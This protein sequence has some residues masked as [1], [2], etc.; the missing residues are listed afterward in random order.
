MTTNDIAVRNGSS[1]AVQ[2]DQTE[3]TDKQLAALKQIGVDSA[4]SGDLAV[5]LHQCQRTGLDPFARQVY[6][7]GRNSQNPRTKQWETKYTIQTG[8]DGYR[9]IARRAADKAREAIG[10]RDTQWCGP[11]GKWVDVWLSE[12]PPAAAKVT[13]VRNGQ[14]FPAIALWREY[15]QTNKDGTPNTMWSRMGANQLAKCAEALAL[16]KAF[17]QDLSGIYTTE[18]MGQAENQR[19]AAPRQQAAK[20]ASLKDAVAQARGTDEPR[21]QAQASKLNALIRENQLTREEALPY[22]SQLI[23]RDITSTTELT[24]AEASKVIDA[25]ESAKDAGAHP[26]TGEIPTEEEPVEAELVDEQ[27]AE[28]WP[29]TAQPGSGA[30]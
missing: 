20:P 15:V 12:E 16:R 8:I 27:P 25:L 1:L 14:D 11:D 21:T 9:L 2:S 3:W 29:E 23:G 17:P 30:R 28:D 13:V 6:M 19:E 7:I 22:F 26:V 5:F 4:S 24:K 10:Y 18:E